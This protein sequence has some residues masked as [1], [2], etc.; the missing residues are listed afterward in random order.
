[1]AA[2]DDP[3]P[4]PQV[5]ALLA[6]AL[7]LGAGLFGATHYLAAGQAAWPLA[8]ALGAGLAG[9]VGS[10]LARRGAGRPMLA[11]FGLLSLFVLLRVWVFV[12]SYPV[13][14]ADSPTYLEVP[15][16][17]AFQRAFTVPLINA[18][19][20]QAGLLK[21]MTFQFLLGLGAWAALGLA[22]YRLLRPG[23]ERLAV[24]GLL[25]GLS[26]SHLVV[27]WDAYILS[28]SV[29]H[30]LVIA[31]FA[32]ALFLHTEIRQRGVGRVSAI[33]LATL[34][35][36][37]FLTLNARD[38]ALYMLPGAIVFFGVYAWKYRVPK[39]FAVVVLALMI[40]MAGVQNQMTNASQRWVD[41]IANVIFRRVLPEP[42][43][44]AYFVE[45]GMPDDSELRALTG[46]FWW[47][48]KYY[49]HQPF[50][51][52][53]KAEGKPTFMGYIIS[54]FP[55]VN[56]DMFEALPET[57]TLSEFK[58]RWLHD[59]PGELFDRL[60][61]Q[62]NRVFFFKLP[63]P[64]FAPLWAVVVLGLALIP[65]PASRSLAMLTLFLGLS[66]YSQVFIGFHGDAA[67]EGRHTILGQLL[68][69]LSLIAGGL[70]LWRL[71]ATARF[72]KPA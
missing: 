36:L 2:C 34:V 21:I 6:Y 28:E 18:L 70:T 60:S 41:P 40:A 61:H 39:G 43:R 16:L 7:V 29:A 68:F 69:R 44:T 58:R 42:D 26:L 62:L 5:A 57:F 52:W 8:L 53:L 20:L 33:L 27:R 59:E 67:D 46:K 35:P 45:R 50:V 1:M 51:A 17:R 12:P 19:L 47:H 4:L 38:S 64:W 11:L 71:A 23:L 22:A 31:V 54:F 13:M 24:P 37:V 66:A 32:L 9:A 48:T 30:S 72:R 15:E 49:E 65:A 14:F 10:A 63:S 56:R 55:Q 3:L 25:W